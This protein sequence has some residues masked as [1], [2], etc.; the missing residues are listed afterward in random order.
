MIPDTADPNDVEIYERG[1][2]L[3]RQSRFEEGFERLRSVSD[4]MPAA[5]GQLAYAYYAH[6]KSEEA[7]PLVRQYIEKIPEDPSGWWLLARLERTQNNLSRAEQYARRAVALQPSNARFWFE[8]GE[9]LFLARRWRDA[10]RVY[11]RCLKLDPEHDQAAVRRSHARRLATQSRIR[12]I[13]WRPPFRWILRRVLVSNLVGEMI[14]T[15]MGVSLDDRRWQRPLELDSAADVSVTP[16]PGQEAD[17][18]LT[19]FEQC[20]CPFWQ[21]F[22]SLPLEGPVRRILEVGVGS[23]NVAQHFASSGFEVTAVTPSELA[24]RDRLRRG[25]VAVKGDFHFIFEKGG[26]FDLVLAG[27]TLRCSRAPLFALWEWKRILRPDGYLLVAQPLYVDPSASSPRPGAKG[28]KS[29]PGNS[30]GAEPHG[31]GTPESVLTL[32][33]W[34]LRWVFKFTGFQLIAET[35]EDPGRASLESVDHVDGRRPHD[36]TKPWTALFLLRKPGNLPYDGALEK[37][38]PPV[39]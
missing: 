37:P 23:G 26:S 7:F 17:R 1:L 24:R 22:R 10:A 20:R 3:L 32:T 19:H 31:V 30:S 28:T 12:A 4:R 15:S 21:W 39:E 33:Y 13:T 25:I 29:Q 38:R 18:F 11:R 6:G 8:L 5:L 35:L 16:P 9:T 14:E 27:E 34:Q 2:E 36:M